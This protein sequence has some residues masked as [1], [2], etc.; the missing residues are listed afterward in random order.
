MIKLKILKGLVFLS[1]S[2]LMLITLASC[3]DVEDINIL[4]TTDVHCEIDDNM[5][6][7]SFKAY[8]NDLLKKDKYVTTIDNGDSIQGGFV[9]AVSKGDYII[10][11]MNEVGYDIWTLGNHEFDYGMDVLSG[12]I[13]KFKGV[14]LSCNIQYVGNNENKLKDVKP[15]EI[16]EYG[17]IKVGYVGVT[18]PASLTESNPS[19]FKEEGVDAYKFSND[20]TKTFYDYVQKNIDDCLNDGAKY[21]VL[22]AHLGYGEECSP[23]GITEVVN[24]TR[25][26]TAV[27]D[28]H[29]HKDI[30]ANYELDL[31][32]NAVPICETGTKL[33]EFGHLVITAAGNV[34]MG[35]VTKYDKEDSKVSE[36]IDN[37]NQ[38]LDEIGN[39]VIA[40]SNVD[41]KITDSDGVRMV[42]TTET[43]IGNLV[44]DAY[45]IVG[46]SNIGIVNGGGIRANLLAGDITYKQ[47]RD[48][49]PFG[50]YICTVEA[51]GQ[52]IADYLE[53][54]SRV[55]EKE[56]KKDGVAKGELGAFAN[57][58]GLKYT[59]DTSIE[60]SVVLDTSFNFKEITGQRRVKDIKVLNGDS[61]E[62]LDL[63]KTY[64]VT[65][66]DYLLISGGDGANMFTKDKVL[67]TGE[68][69]DYQVLISYIQ[70]SLNGNLATKYSNT[71]GRITII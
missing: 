67:A 70:N 48:V 33:K 34:R 13:N 39:E 62:P 11:I 32:G 24:N 22:V 1:L 7:T 23:W 29:T 58:S 69:Y 14:T 37:I 3:G 28:G 9:G 42:R 16:I 31:D 2:F 8:K 36:L 12:L 65:S 10:D 49:H 63:N 66:H 20:T 25:N 52:Q 27:I 30:A 38:K 43:P 64:T 45:R 51:T 41:L 15:Y 50:N 17:D 5:G 18:T 71:E 19:S 46:K 68:L 44:A 55:T 40:H 59:I 56:Y 61:Y 35:Y 26:V 6:Y 57:V 53:F 4:F 54:T 21:V 47:V 60:S